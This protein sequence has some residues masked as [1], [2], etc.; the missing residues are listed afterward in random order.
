M[1]S[2]FWRGMFEN[3]GTKLNFSSAYHPKMDGQSKVANSIVLDLL[4]SYVGEVAQ[5]NQW[6]K[7]LLLMEYA[8]NN[9][10]H[11]STSKTPFEVI[12]GRPRLPLILKPHNKIFATDEEVQDIRVAFD[13]IKDSI[14]LAQQKYKRA[15]DKHKKSLDF[16]EDDWVLL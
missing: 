3:L 8:Y 5:A 6:E 9:T 12:E 14:S 1:T 15:T 11:S 4:K 2:L 16:Q 10:I 13:K 7:Y